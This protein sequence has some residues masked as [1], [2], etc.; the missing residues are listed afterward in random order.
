M[1]ARTRKT[2]KTYDDEGRYVA[3]VTTNAGAYSPPKAEAKPGADE[4]CIKEAFGRIQMVGEVAP[5][6]PNG[7]LT[8]PSAFLKTIEEKAGVR[9]GPQGGGMLLAIVDRR[10]PK[11][12]EVKE[13]MQMPGSVVVGP[14]QPVARSGRGLGH[15]MQNGQMHQRSALGAARGGRGALGSSSGRSQGGPQTNNRSGIKMIP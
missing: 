11:L 8:N 4:K 10:R 14:P 12:E 15:L 5:R 6:N 13:C 1:R 3:S 9:F 2:R 7:S